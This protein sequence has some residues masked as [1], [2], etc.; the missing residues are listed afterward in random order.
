MTL[1]RNRAAPGAVIWKRLVD[2]K[3]RQDMV[4]RLRFG[5][6]HPVGKRKGKNRR[7]ALAFATLF[8]PAA[9]MAYVLGAWRLASDLQIAGNFGIQQGIFSHWQVWMALGAA[10]NIAAVSLNRYGRGG[11]LRLPFRY[12]RKASAPPDSEHSLQNQSTGIS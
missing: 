6:G 7:V 4:V 3:Y 1:Y 12:G 2:W 5:R 10:V 9:L 8:A 11:E